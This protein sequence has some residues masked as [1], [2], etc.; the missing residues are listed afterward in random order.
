MFGPQNVVL[1]LNKVSRTAPPQSEMNIYVLFQNGIFELGIVSC[2]LPN[3]V[4]SFKFLTLTLIWSGEKLGWS[5][6]LFG[7]SLA[8]SKSVYLVYIRE[9]SIHSV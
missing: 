9:S 2:Q 7:L 4:K 3:K 5:I 1:A 8:C 6:R